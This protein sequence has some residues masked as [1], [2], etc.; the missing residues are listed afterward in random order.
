MKKVLNAFFIQNVPDTADTKVRP[1]H[2][3]G[4]ACVGL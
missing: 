1:Q 3:N 2:R 4:T